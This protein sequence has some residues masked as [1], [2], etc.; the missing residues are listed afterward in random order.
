[1]LGRALCLLGFPKWCPV[2]VCTHR[3]LEM[4]ILVVVGT[5]GPVGDLG[6]TGLM[7][8]IKS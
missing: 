8:A 3:S 4:L 5:P 6:E 1:M 7:I 2:C